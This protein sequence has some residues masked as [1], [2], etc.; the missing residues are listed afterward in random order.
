MTDWEN[1]KGWKESFED[2]QKIIMS[3]YALKSLRRLPSYQRMTEGGK[4]N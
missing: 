2:Q 4:R 3:L 1:D